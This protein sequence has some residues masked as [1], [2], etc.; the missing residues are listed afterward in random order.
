MYR[1]P[2]TKTYINISIDNIAQKSLSLVNR[3]FTDSSI[4]NINLEVNRRFTDS[5]NNNIKQEA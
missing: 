2:H 1:E 3:R 4:K 5:N